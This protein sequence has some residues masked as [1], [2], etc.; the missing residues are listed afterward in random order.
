MIALAV[1][2]T[3][4]AVLGAILLVVA[5]IR[6][7]SADGTSDDVV[8]IDALVA[9]LAV[10]LTATVLVA[11]GGVYSYIEDMHKPPAIV[12]RVPH[13][14]VVPVPCTERRTP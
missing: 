6:T 14:V 2:F 13:P 9:W 3:A 11:A 10:V 1:V 8:A 7:A 4:G 12:V 5:I